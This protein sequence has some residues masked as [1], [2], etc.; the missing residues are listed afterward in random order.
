M[1]SCGTTSEINWHPLG[2]E[3]SRRVP[4]CMRNARDEARNN[5]KRI[6]YWGEIENVP[7]DICGRM[8]WRL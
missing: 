3:E 5:S 4:V 8:Q 7:N 1:R 2:R 6:W